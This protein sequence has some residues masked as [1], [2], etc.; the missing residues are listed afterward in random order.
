[1]ALTSSLPDR[2]IFAPKLTQKSRFAGCLR[3]K[4][5]TLPVLFCAFFFRLSFPLYGQ[6]QIPGELQN[7][8][9]LTAA[10]SASP[11]DR[12]AAFRRLARLEALAG[13]MES[14]AKTWY[15]AA[16]ANPA[17]PDYASL[18]E[19]VR[20]YIALGDYPAADGALYIVLSRAALPA[21][22]REAQYFTAVSAAFRT[23][24]GTALAS[25]L[26]SPDY[27]DKRPAIL[28]LLWLLTGSEDHRTRLKRDFPQS[29]ESM[30]LTETP[31]ASVTAAARP[32][33]FFFSGREGITLGAASRF[34]PPAAAPASPEAPAA[35]PAAGSPPDP[36]GTGA[37]LL[38]T[39]LFSREENAGTMA[40]RLRA[41]GFTPVINRR[42]VN[43]SRYYVVG[44]APGAAI[45][46]TIL[47]LK[48]AGFEAF[49]VFTP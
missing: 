42:D 5:V 30:I 18:L 1:M 34:G 29:P 3:R 15:T 23:G 11:A 4:T 19:A 12:A 21:L 48:D 24:D 33:W 22:L 16:F 31:A 20:C 41:A 14:A 9:A 25:L 6:I 36:A 2:W 27:G 43:G 10:P 45:N 49:P 35:A 26:E 39:G 38:Q 17:S 7:L 32:M 47:H 28:Y 40:D 8:K 46:D 37:T 44:V 13:D